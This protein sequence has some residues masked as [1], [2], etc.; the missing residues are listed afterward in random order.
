MS[1]HSVTEQSIAVVVR[2]EYPY[3]LDLYVEIDPDNGDVFVDSDV[4][5][6]EGTDGDFVDTIGVEE[7][8]R[9]AVFTLP[10]GYDTVEGV[11][12]VND[13]LE[14]MSYVI[15]GSPTLF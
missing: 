14:S 6:A 2:R 1:K 3:I 5:L 4:T 15:P 8:I 12:D 10:G 7:A 9:Q 11:I 13:V